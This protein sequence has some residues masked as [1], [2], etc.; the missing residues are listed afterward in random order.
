MPRSRY[1]SPFRQ[2]ISEWWMRRSIIAV[3]A[4]S[5]PKISP[6]ARTGCCCDDHRRAFVTVGDEAGHE[7]RGPISWRS[8]TLGT[9]ARGRRTGYEDSA[10]ARGDATPP[11]LAMGYSS[12]LV[13]I[14]EN[15]RATERVTRTGREAGLYTMRGG[16]LRIELL[17]TVRGRAVARSC[18]WPGL[19]VLG[20]RD[21]FENVEA[22]GSRLLLADLH[23]RQQ[24]AVDQRDQSAPHAR[25]PSAPTRT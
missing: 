16:G 11:S 9:S 7:V 18:W 4:M 6:Y 19:G 15:Q 22:A 1:L 13:Y 14:C 10:A 17:D 25:P 5:S 3:A 23:P 8:S 12:G 20:A 2:R 21:S 24:L